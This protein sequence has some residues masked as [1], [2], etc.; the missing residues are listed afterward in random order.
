MRVLQFKRMYLP[1]LSILAVVLLLLILI[2]VS[3]YRNLDREEKTVLKFVHQQGLTLLHALEAGARTDMMMPRRHKDTIALFIQ[4]AGKN[5]DIAYIYLI[6]SRG[7]VVHHSNSSLEGLSSAW[8]PQLDDKKEVQ[9]RI[10]KLSDGTKV[11]DLAKRFLPNLWQFSP[12]NPDGM[13][14]NNRYMAPSTHADTI[15]VLGLKMAQFEAARRSD[16]HHAM[17]M[18]AVLVV[19]GSGALFFIFVIQNYYL[20]DRTLKQ[21]RDY[22]RQ[23]VANMANGL[24]SINS[25]GRIA[26]YNLLALELLDLNGSEV[27]GMDLKSV[28]DFKK[29]GIENTL[30]TCQAMLEQEY[31]YRNRAGALVPISLSVTP[32]LDEKKICTGAVIVL[33]DLR[34]IKRL[35][36][37]VRHSE[38]LAAI[39]KL[40]AGVAHEIRNPLSSIRGFARFLAHSLA[41]QSQ[42]QEYAEVMV[43]EVD[44]INSVVNDLLTFARPLE[45]DLKPTDV[46]ALMEHTL[47]LV[48]GDARSRNV[49]IRST[50]SPNLGRLHLDANQITQALLN[51]ILNALQEVERGGKIEVFAG[52]E[53]SGDRLRI[54]V[55][56]DGPGVSPDKKEKIFEPFFTT[57]EKGTGLGLAIVQK[58]VENHRGEIQVDSPFPG[59][60]RGCRFTVII[61]ITTTENSKRESH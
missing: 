55:E 32:I 44:R 47:R 48:E 6:D 46:A 60:K 14:E 50:I 59:K 18:A 36:E 31:H 45:P 15:M 34:E 17:I 57:G 51:L 38:K 35:E 8:Q 33:R 56:D 27:S 2:G 21:T 16:I 49:D 7:I 5:N 9:N 3:T 10:R 20:V 25:D 30:N 19:L 12:D 11:Y 13:T 54:W 28:I 22:T 39:G 43:K 53:H 37:E 52:L 41:D 58:I 26:S 29:A 23:V 4:E 40:A 61:P 42:E 24:V 1:A